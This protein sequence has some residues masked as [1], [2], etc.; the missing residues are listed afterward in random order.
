MTITKEKFIEIMN[1]YQKYSENARRFSKALG[2]VCDGWPVVTISEPLEK[3]IFNLLED[4]FDDKEHQFIS[5]WA[6]ELEFGKNAKT[7][8]AIFNKKQ[9]ILQTAGELYD[10]LILKN[11]GYDDAKQRKNY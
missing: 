6:F 2:E 1:L 10:F 5:W 7:Y 9:Y 4:A 8:P 3:I 11:Q